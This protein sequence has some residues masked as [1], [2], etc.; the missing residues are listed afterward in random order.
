MRDWWFALGSHKGNS[1]CMV[2]LE[3]LPWYV[4]FIAWFADY[5]C[6]YVPEIPFPSWIKTKTET[7]EV[8]S[9]YEYYGDLKQ[10]Y[11]CHVL[12][13]IVTWEMTHPKRREYGVKCGYSTAKKALYQDHKDYF[14][15]HELN[16]KLDNM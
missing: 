14:D 12:M 1:F 11:F 3:M 2:Y 9:L 4:R 10:L 16:E 7:G 13:P 6:R 8:V 15:E 5:L